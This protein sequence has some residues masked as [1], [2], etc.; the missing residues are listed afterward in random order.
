MIVFAPTKKMLIWRHEIVLK[1]QYSNFRH[2]LQ[3]H[4]LLILP[5]L[6]RNLHHF[7]SYIIL[8]HTRSLL[9]RGLCYCFTM[10]IDTFGCA[11]VLGGTL[12]EKLLMVC[13]YAS[14]M[15]MLHASDVSQRSTQA[16]NVIITRPLTELPN[17]GGVALSTPLGTKSGYFGP[18]HSLPSPLLH[19]QHLL[20]KTSPPH[21]CLLYLNVILPDVKILFPGGDI[22]GGPDA[23]LKIY[24]LVV[25]RTELTKLAGT[26]HR[27][28]RNNTMSLVAQ[29]LARVS[30]LAIWC[31]TSK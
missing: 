8:S 28:H 22:P 31:H 16:S 5:L 9:L 26:D 29:V 19:C 4:Q 6:C 14:L 17:S 2:M 23:A 13:K 20:Y 12:V 27:C 15:R 24:S 10:H 25:T 7:S 3:W 21:H 18:Y 30:L 1:F 11:F